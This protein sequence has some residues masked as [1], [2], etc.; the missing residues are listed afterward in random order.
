MMRM[1]LAVKK[2][3]AT[4]LPARENF[5]MPISVPMR[6]LQGM[7]C[8]NISMT[9]C[10][11]LDLTTAHSFRQCLRMHRQES[12]SDCLSRTSP[13]L[14][15]IIWKWE[16]IWSLCFRP[17]ASALFQSMTDMTVNSRTA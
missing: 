17:W 11:A 3:K 12:L 7:R 15:G 10:P 9:G 6:N 14:A 16:I 5:C 1:W 8:W 2:K 4:A 13:A